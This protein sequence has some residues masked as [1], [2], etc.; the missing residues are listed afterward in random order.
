MRR[1]NDCFTRMQCAYFLSRLPCFLLGACGVMKRF[2]ILCLKRT[3]QVS[4]HL[5][6]W[7]KGVPG[8]QTIQGRHFLFDPCNIP[9]ISVSVPYGNIIVQSLTKCRADKVSACATP[10]RIVFASSYRLWNNSLCALNGVLRVTRFVVHR[11]ESETAEA[12]KEGQTR[13]GWCEG[14]SEWLSVCDRSL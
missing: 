1:V 13:F 9:L 6:S 8:E 14:N 2:S 11:R 10:R 7:G 3:L 12:A 5:P 4:A